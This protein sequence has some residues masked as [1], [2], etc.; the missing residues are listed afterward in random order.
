MIT[1]LAELKRA[2]Q[3]GASVTMTACNR[4]PDSDLVGVTRTVV[5]ADAEN[6]GFET[7]HADGSRAISYLHWPKDDEVGFTDAG[8]IAH[9]ATYRQSPD[10]R[11]PE[12]PSWSTSWH[13]IAE[14]R[15]CLAGHKV[16]AT[17]RAVNSP[18]RFLPITP[19]T[20]LVKCLSS[21][22]G[23]HSTLMPSRESAHR[24]EVPLARPPANA[25]G[26]R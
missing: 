22:A 9:G 12:P 25:E 15:G 7:V 23:P 26:G 24:C 16:I 10:C 19:T 5:R 20:F 13:G 8:F 14:K 3:P 18:L 21:R 6:V 17:A 1:S 2:L 4:H 11:A